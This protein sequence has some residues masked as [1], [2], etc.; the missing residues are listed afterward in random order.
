MRI[1]NRTIKFKCGI[2]ESFEKCH[3]VIFRKVGEYGIFL[4]KD[5]CSAICILIDVDDEYQKLVDRYDRDNYIITKFEIPI[6]PVSE[7]DIN[8]RWSGE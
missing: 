4:C 5:C 7:N 1:L 6:K 8:P 2:C 3:I